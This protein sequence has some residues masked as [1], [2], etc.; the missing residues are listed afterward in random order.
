LP[1]PSQ[2]THSL[3]APQFHKICLWCQDTPPGLARRFGADR[4]E[5]SPSPSPHSSTR[6]VCSDAALS[7]PHCPSRFRRVWRVA[8]PAISRSDPPVLPSASSSP[9]SPCLYI[10]T[11]RA[12]VPI[13]RLYIAGCGLK[14]SHHS[15]PR[16]RGL[17][18][19]ATAW[20]LHPRPAIHLINLWPS[21]SNNRDCTRGIQIRAARPLRR[22]ES[23]WT[24]PAV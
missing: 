13:F 17:T 8:R 2:D 3:T 18:D 4:P 15:I 10:P 21:S 5:P 22:W 9:A 1:S 19:D 6:G 12:N 14:S 23:V 24:L 16:P 20:S 11:K 7:P